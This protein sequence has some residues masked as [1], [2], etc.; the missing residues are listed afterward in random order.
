M[1]RFTKTL[2]GLFALGAALAASSCVDNDSSFFIYGV[3]DIN[4]SQ[5]IAKPDSNSAL[6]AEGTLDRQFADGYKAAILVGSHLTQRGNREKL[7]T[8]TAR[9]SVTGAHITLY[10]TEGAV[11]EFDTPATGLVN[12]SSGTDPGLAAVFARLVRYDDMA[13]LGR[14]GQMIARVKILGTTLGGQDIES[15]TFDY[16]ITLCT[17]CLVTYPA[18]A[19]SNSTPP[20]CDAS[21]D[22][23]ADTTICFFGQDYYFPCTVCAS[24][25]KACESPAYNPYRQ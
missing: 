23:A 11:I 22:T 20:T 15:A 17:G 10:G 5:C 1:Q 3:M 21:T 7:R 12:P 2:A 9:L 4:S 18:D 8:E 24:F 16:P 25:D 13:K 6:I 19:L 14:D